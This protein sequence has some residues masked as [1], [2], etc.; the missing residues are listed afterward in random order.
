MCLIEP[1]RA[2]QNGFTPLHFAAIHGYP[3]VID[4]LLAAGADKDAKGKVRRAGD[5]D[6]I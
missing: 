4:Q 2:P 6:C 3:A 5:E 1:C